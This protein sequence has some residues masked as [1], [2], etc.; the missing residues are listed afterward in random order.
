MGVISL[1][2]KKERDIRGGGRYKIGCLEGFTEKVA[3]EE[4][5]KE[6]RE[7]AR[8]RQLGTPFQA[9]GTAI[10]KGPRYHRTSEPP[11]NLLLGTAW[12]DTG[13]LGQPGRQVGRLLRYYRE[14]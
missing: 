7:G 11:V 3:L 10:E 6:V 14:G 8:R 9:Q 13:W 5:L 4:S 2:R 1:E 12:E